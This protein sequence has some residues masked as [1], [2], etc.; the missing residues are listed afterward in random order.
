M[1]FFWAGYIDEMSYEYLQELSPE[2]Y[3]GANNLEVDGIKS[4]L[5]SLILLPVDQ[6]PPT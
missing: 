4:K 6:F 5:L 1:I 3:Y 2:D